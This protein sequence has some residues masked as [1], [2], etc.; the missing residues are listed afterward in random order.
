MEDKE[1][2]VEMIERCVSADK[3]ELMTRLRRKLAGCSQ[4]RDNTQ[5]YHSTI[6]LDTQVGQCSNCNLSGLLV[7][8]FL[9]VFKKLLAL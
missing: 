3:E 6:H 1:T 2:L 8:V 7:L 4:C 5:Y 9:L